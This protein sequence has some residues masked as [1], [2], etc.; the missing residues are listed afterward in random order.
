MFC[1][2]AMAYFLVFLAPA[3]LAGNFYVFPTRL[4]FGPQASTG[5]ITVS[6]KVNEPL[7][8]QVGAVKWT[9]DASGKDVY[10]DTKDVIFF[11]K[12]ASLNGNEQRLV[13]AGVQLP[14]SAIE[15]T[16]RLFIGEIPQPKKPG[17]TQI[18]VAI[19]FGIPVFVAPAKENP[20]GA[21]GSLEISKGNLNILAKNTGN[22]HFILKTLQ[23]RG[24][25]PKGHVKFSK[26]IP[27]WYL[28][29][30]AS[31]LY[32]TPITKV[33][34][35]GLSRIEVKAVTDRP[36]LN[37]SGSLEMKKEMCGA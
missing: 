35:L 19:R 8:I 30:G 36:D 12:V 27:G 14:P 1:L 32:T 7:N 29:A 3:A 23:V 26:D 11:P 28:L 13:R 6:N 21:I 31:R 25:D 4:D 9:E 34:C 18:S 22:V 15:R 24:T 5:A 2:A 10:S 33:Q 37:F 17:Q 20:A 16:Y